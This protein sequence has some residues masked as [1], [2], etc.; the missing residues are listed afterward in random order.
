MWLKMWFS[1]YNTEEGSAKF[2]G[3]RADIKYYQTE[4]PNDTSKFY[5]MLFLVVL[6]ISSEDSMTRHISFKTSSMP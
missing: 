2:I 3:I 1:V 4:L 6:N 5:W